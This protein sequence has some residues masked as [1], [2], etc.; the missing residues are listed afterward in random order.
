MVPD[1]SLT[2]ASASLWGWMI[3][4]WFLREPVKDLARAFAAS[5]THVA[6]EALESEK[7]ALVERLRGIEE[8]LVNQQSLASNSEKS[9]QQEYAKL[10]EKYDKRIHATQTGQLEAVKTDLLQERDAR[11][12]LKIEL[13][14][15]KNA[16]A[17]EVE[18]LKLARDG[19]RALLRFIH[20]GHRMNVKFDP[21]SIHAA[22]Q[23]TNE[24]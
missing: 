24:K 16:Q 7:T 19:N 13:D 15:L 17:Q 2:K 6:I 4:C 10:K 8:E 11:H 14:V 23:R 22:L 21:K 9:H 12:L 20:I 3:H 18:A 5:P 1:K